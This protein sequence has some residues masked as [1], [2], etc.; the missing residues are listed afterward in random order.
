MR[1]SDT[2]GRLGGDEFLAILPETALD[3]ALHVAEK[4]REALEQPYPLGKAAA[5]LSASIGVS[6]YPDHG[7][8]GETLQRAADAALYQ[9][10]REGR[11]KVRVAGGK[12]R[13]AE[14][15][16]RFEVVT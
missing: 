3:G 8:D 9:A 12:P 15:A 5:K 14:G 11:N 4:L 16:P 2:V 7:A 6:L 10:K 1:A 13:G